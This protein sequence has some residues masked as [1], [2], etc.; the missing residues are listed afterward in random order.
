MGADDTEGREL[1]TSI[2]DAVPDADDRAALAEMCR[3]ARDI[4]E[5]KSALEST[6][7]AIMADIKELAGRIGVPRRVIGDGWE[8]RKTTSTRETIVAERLMERGVPLA[9][10]QD[11]TKVTTSESYGLYGVKPAKEA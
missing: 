7:K 11:S 8:L 5:E 6:Y 2:D 1:P 10:I 4:S 3:V 9:V